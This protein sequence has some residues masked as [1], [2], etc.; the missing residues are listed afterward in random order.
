MTYIERCPYLQ[1]TSG[2]SGE[3]DEY[4]DGADICT[5]VDKCCLLN[6]D[7]KCDAYEEFLNEL[8]AQESA[9]IESLKAEYEVDHNEN[10]GNCPHK[11]IF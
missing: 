5:L 10:F 7:C 9:E 8:Q 4:V 1:D 6:G 3:L 11:G 2:Y